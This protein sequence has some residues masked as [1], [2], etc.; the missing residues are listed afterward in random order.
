[1]RAAPVAVPPATRTPTASSR[2]TETWVY[3]LLAHRDAGR[4]RRGRQPVEHGHGRLGRVG[5]GH[6]HAGH[7]DRAGGR[8]S[9]ST[10]RPNPTTYNAV[11]Q[12]ITYSYM[13]TNT[14]NV[15]LIGHLVADDKS[16]PS[17]ARRPDVAGRPR[18]SPARSPHDH[19]A[20]LDNGSI[21][22]IATAPGAITR[23]DTDHH[24]VPALTSTSGARLQPLRTG[25]GHLHLSAD[26]QRQRHAVGFTVSDNKRPRDVTCPQP[27]LAPAR[28]HL[29]RDYTPPRPSWTQTAPRSRAT[30]TCPTRTVDR[31][32]CLGRASLNI[33]STRTRR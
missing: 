33:P 20:D 25:D 12:V 32:R 15:T 13:V 8:R 5:A 30:T 10:S 4:G 9:G 23:Q 24:R 21:T 27:S 3:R 31:T 28:H 16:A 19:A 26:Q 7:P 14:G 17:T 18:Q 6:R 29:H 22:N 11:G 1:M 2:L